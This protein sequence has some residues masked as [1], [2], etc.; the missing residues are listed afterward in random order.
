MGIRDI[1]YVSSLV[2][3]RRCLLCV[4]Y[5]SS[6]GILLWLFFVVGRIRRVV[7]LWL[8]FF[9]GASSSSLIRLRL[10]LCLVII[11]IGFIFVGYAW[12]LEWLSLV[13]RLLVFFFGCA[14]FGSKL[15]LLILPLVVLIPC[16]VLFVGL[17]WSYS[18][19]VVFF[20]G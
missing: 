9:V 16:V 13:V 3:L 17:L 5:Y 4:A 10:W 1:G 6:M 20:S 15:S 11:I 19:L 8:G 14:Y 7:V 2:A 12:Y 18:S